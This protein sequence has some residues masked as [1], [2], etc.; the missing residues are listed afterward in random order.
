MAISARILDMHVWG[1]CQKYQIVQQTYQLQVQYRAR[2][3]QEPVGCIGLAHRCLKYCEGLEKTCKHVKNSQKLPNDTN[4][5]V[6]RKVTGRSGTWKDIHSAWNG[7]KTTPRMPWNV[8]K[9]WLKHLQAQI[10]RQ[11]AWKGLQTCLL[12]VAWVCGALQR[13]QKWLKMWMKMSQHAKCNGRIFYLFHLILSRASILSNHG[14]C[15]IFLLYLWL[16]LSQ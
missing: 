1:K 10:A 12:D 2:K 5:V 9:N 14:A 3:T 13:I 8:R 7:T 15:L 16:W 4:A 6:L 11:I